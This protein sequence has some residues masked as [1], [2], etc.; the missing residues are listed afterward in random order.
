MVAI[1]DMEMPND[2]KKC[3]LMGTDGDPKDAFSPMMCIAIWATTHKIKHCVS[4]K[5]R[6]DCPLVEIEGRKVGKWVGDKAYPVC[7]KCGCNIIEEYIS[8][9][10]YAE[11]YKPMKFCPNCGEGMEENSES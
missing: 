7:P 8:C 2:C 4:G 11:I 5:T 10:D 6:D 3:P 9:A 1:E